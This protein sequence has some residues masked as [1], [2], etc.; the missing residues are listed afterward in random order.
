MLINRSRL[1]AFVL[2]A[3]AW[4]GVWAQEAA[5]D[6]GLVNALQGD[7]S[8]Q[9]KDGPAR[10]AQAYMRLRHGDK[11]TLAA[12]ASIRISHF[13]TGRQ[14]S[15][16]AAGSFVATSSGGE[17]LKGSKPEVVQL[18]A[19]APQKL[20]RITDWMNRSGFGGMVVR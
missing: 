13:T 20:A 3:L 10:K 19:V 5:G 4:S 9:S 11:V 1:V 2:A 18:P 15:W 17:A 7:V 8:Y 14:E 6:V 12:D 16:T